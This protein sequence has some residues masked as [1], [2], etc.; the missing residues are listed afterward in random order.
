MSRHCNVSEPR[1]SENPTDHVV[2]TCCS[3]RYWEART[4]SVTHRCTYGYPKGPT[5]FWFQWLHTGIEKGEQHSSDSVIAA[6]R[7]RYG[8]RKG[9]TTFFWFSYCRTQM[10]IRVSKRENNILLIQLLPHTDADTGI[11]KSESNIVL[12]HRCTCRYRKG[13]TALFWF[14]D[15]HTQM[16]IRVWKRTALFW[17]SDCH[18]QIHIR[19]SI[20][21]NSSVLIQ[22]LP[23]KMHIRVWKRT[24]L[25]W[26]SDCRT[27]MHMQVSIR[28][29]SIV[30]I[31]WL[32]HTDAHSGMEKNSIVL[33]QW[34]PHTD[35]HASIDKGEQHCSDSVS[36]C[37]TQMHIQ[38]SRKE[39]NVVLTQWLPL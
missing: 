34:L 26:F 16:H 9:R 25:F 35:A 28:E 36:D 29:N 18:S 21:E 12:I 38:V 3:D 6:H 2:A 39:K 14:N 5:L 13:R 37:H 19:V 1:V 23:H 11:E 20:R 8:Y 27:Q 31:Q 24:A 7:C 22:W 33:I 15:C 10:Q 17:F 4:D 32:P 30:L